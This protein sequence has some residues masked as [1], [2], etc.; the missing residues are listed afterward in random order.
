MDVTI[1]DPFEC[2]DVAI[3]DKILG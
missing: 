1:S 2:S 3:T